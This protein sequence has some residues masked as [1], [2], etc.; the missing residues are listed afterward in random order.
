MSVVRL[1]VVSNELEAEMLCSLLRTAGI[2]CGQRKTDWAAGASDGSPSAVGPREVLVDD[3][4]LEAA[5]EILAGV[6]E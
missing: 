6:G 3:A 4:D 2:A 5:R 1:T